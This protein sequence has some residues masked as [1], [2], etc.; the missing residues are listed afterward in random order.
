[1]KKGVENGEGGM[2]P[3]QAKFDLTRLVWLY[4]DDDYA[5]KDLNFTIHP[6]EKV[7]FS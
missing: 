3:K 1:M 5:I 4:K 2:V 6:G 7:A